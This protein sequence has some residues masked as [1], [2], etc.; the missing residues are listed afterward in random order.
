MMGLV[1]PHTLGQGELHMPDLEAH[2]MT[3]PAALVTQAQAA[4][5]P[6]QVSVGNS[7]IAVC[8]CLRLDFSAVG[9]LTTH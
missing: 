8:A 4:E 7:E 6:A 1:V 5:T 9:T 3:D 2:A